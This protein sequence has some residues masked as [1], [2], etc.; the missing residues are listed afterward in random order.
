MPANAAGFTRPPAAYRINGRW[1][2]GAFYLVG[3]AQDF[4]DVGAILTAI[5]SGTPDSNGNVSVTF[6][7]EGQPP[8]KQ[9]GN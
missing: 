6:D 5:G 8:I 4:L 7:G 2:G 9:A 3:P 1:K